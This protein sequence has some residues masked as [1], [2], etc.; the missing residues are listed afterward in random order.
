MRFVKI[1]NALVASP[2]SSAGEGKL[3]EGVFFQRIDASLVKQEVKLL[4][5]ELGEGPVEAGEVVGIAGVVGQMDI[6]VALFF[7]EREVAFGVDGASEGAWIV[8]EHGGSAV[9]LMD[10]EIE[11][12]HVSNAWSLE[13]RKSTDGEIVEDAVS[14]AKVA[15]GVVS[16]AGHIPGD[17]AVLEHMLQGLQT[18][19]GDAEGAFDNGGRPRAQADA[20]DGFGRQGAFEE[21]IYI[22]GGVRHDEFGAGGLT[23]ALD[24][25]VGAALE[26]SSQ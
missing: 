9:A 13:R 20:P 7:A 8:G 17:T 15:V 3:T 11:N 25:D 6:E 24:V 21:T 19:P 23:G 16:A 14:G 5:R 26:A 12:E 4:D 2:Q 10:I 1:E 22:V 18:P